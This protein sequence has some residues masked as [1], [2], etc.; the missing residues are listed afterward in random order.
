MHTPFRRRTLVRLAALA[1]TALLVAACSGGTGNG[2]ITVSGAWSR[3]S[4]MVAGAGAAYMVI[5]NTGSEAD[6]LVGAASDVAAAVEVHE[7][8]DMSSAMPMA[9][10]PAESMGMDGEESP[11]AST[12]MGSGGSMLGMQ[13]VDRVEIPAGGTVELK[14]GGYHIMLI[15]LTRELQV[16]EQIEI[17]LT[18][19]KAGEVTV[20]AEVREG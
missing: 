7:T 19:E 4:P 16:G 15:G 17:T 3:P 20:T 8:V 12:D 14:P 18:F 5:E 11:G 1:L 13:R 2:G 6:A 10:T 9:S